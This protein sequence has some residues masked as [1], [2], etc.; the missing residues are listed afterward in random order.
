MTTNKILLHIQA[1]TL[2]IML[3]LN[4]TLVFAELE[5]ELTPCEEI[6]PRLPACNDGMENEALPQ[7]DGNVDLE[8]AQ[9]AS[10]RD[11]SETFDGLQPAI[12]PVTVCMETGLF[13]KTRL[14]Q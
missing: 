13:F 7:L 5:L 3:S 9:C 12:D 10:Q 14:C 2:L 4:S 1:L 11:D 8:D 6:G